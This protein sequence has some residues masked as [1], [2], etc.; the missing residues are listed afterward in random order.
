M[1]ADREK[2]KEVRTRLE[3]C[4]QKLPSAGAPAG[5]AEHVDIALRRLNSFLQM[6]DKWDEGNRS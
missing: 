5:I 4:L 1:N 2:L 3:E 6:I